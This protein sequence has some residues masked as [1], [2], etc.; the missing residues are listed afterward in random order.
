M[1]NYYPISG[2]EGMMFIERNCYN[3]Y[4][5]KTCTIL[6]NSLLGMQ[7]KQWVYNEDNEAICTSQR[8]E[9]QKKVEKINQDS[10]ELFK[11]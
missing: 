7:P 1:R 8:M 4:K 10:K 2:M 6:T 5:E 9:R 11:D 3:C